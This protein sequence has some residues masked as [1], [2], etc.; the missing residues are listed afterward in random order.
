M[1]DPQNVK[2]GIAPIAWTNDDMPEL[3]AENTFEQCISEMALAGFKGC[4]VGSKYPKD[5]V[6]LRKKLE[7]RGLVVC[8]QWFSSLVTSEGVEATL[9]NFR[10]QIAFLQ[11]LGAKI[12]GASEQG[13]SIQGKDLPIFEAKP[14][15]TDEEWKRFADACN[16]MGRIARDVGLTFTYHHHMGTVVQTEEEVDRFLETTDPD[17]VFLLYDSGHFTFSGEDPVKMIRK[18]VQ[19]VRHVHLK[20]VRLPVLEEVRR[21]KLSFLQAVRRGAFTV[22]GDGSIDF[23][24][25]FKVLDEN[26]YK[27]WMLV[28]AEQDPA[29][30][31]PYDY[32]VKARRYIREQCGL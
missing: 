20:D 13:N 5:P 8:N 1:F 6:V 22:P 25:I 15:L 9:R 23:P 30:A 2:L 31:N 29:V 26:H 19:R 28:E 17:L 24:S 21:D 27:G 4:E 16:R 10:E 18:Y 32:A 3:G 7:S 11:A 14:H 12:I